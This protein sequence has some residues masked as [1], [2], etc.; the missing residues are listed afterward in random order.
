M[1]KIALGLVLGILTVCTIYAEDAPVKNKPTSAKSIISGTVTDKLTGEALTGVEVKLMDSDVSIYTDFEGKFEI[2]DVQPG[3]HAIVIN[4][5]SYQDLV[6]NIHTE[7]GNTSKVTIK[8][9][10]VEQ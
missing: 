3:A 8:L 6:E 5:I 10:S 4:Y 9:K 2:K 1:R 7:A